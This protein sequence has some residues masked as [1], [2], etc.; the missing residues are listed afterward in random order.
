VCLVS[1]KFTILVPDYSAKEY[2]WRERAVL[3]KPDICAHYQRL[4]DSGKVEEAKAFLGYEVSIL[5][6][7]EQNSKIPIPG[8]T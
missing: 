3:Q 5:K 6:I 1:E 7:H 4:K 2:T 8:E